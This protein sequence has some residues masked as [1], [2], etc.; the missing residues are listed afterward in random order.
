MRACLKDLLDDA[1]AG[2]YAV[3]CFN[4]FGH[5]DARAVVDEAESRGAPVILATNREMTDFLGVEGAVALFG[6]VARTATTPVCL[7]LDHCYDVELACRAVDAGYDSVMYDGSQLS[8]E[9]NIRDTRR[10]A[11]HAH[12]QGVGVEGEIGSVGYSETGNRGREHIRFE[13]T[14]PDQAQ[15]FAERSG[16]DAVAVSIGNVHRLESR[17]GEVDLERV[18]AIAAVVAQP[19]VV[20]GTSGIPD[21]QLRALSRMAVCK[22]NI[23][24]ALRQR[25]G[26]AL[27]ATLAE[28]PDEYDRLTIFGHV[29]PAMRQ[30][31]GRFFDLLMPSA[32]APLDPP[33]DFPIDPSSDRAPDRV[34]GK[35]VSP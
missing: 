26:Q 25:F 4:V 24:T 14:E 15:A 13:L 10:V 8:L 6:H 20:H 17:T 11:D 3:P 5:E 21:Q 2:G 12:A 32:D 28:H 9:R 27:R 34:R 1:L 16:V 33:D 7:H 35:T 19:L 29:M 31:A 30:E 22:F 18:R 23:G